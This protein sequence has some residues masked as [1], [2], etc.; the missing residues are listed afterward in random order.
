MQP[1]HL[2]CQ[3]AALPIKMAI[4]SLIPH[5]LQAEQC[6]RLGLRL[7]QRRARSLERRLLI[8]TALLMLRLWLVTAFCRRPMS[9]A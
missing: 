1:S 5:V 4:H 7:T 8:S 2:L 3:Q 9:S 6:Y